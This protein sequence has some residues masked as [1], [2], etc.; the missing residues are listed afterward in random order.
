MELKPIETSYNGYR[1]R[2]RLEARWAVFFDTVGIKWEYETEG[3]DLGDAGWYL[4][5]FWLPE[6]NCFI[7]IKGKKPTIEECNKVE[8]LFLLSGFP[9]VL[10]YGLPFDNYG[11]AYCATDKTD[12]SGGCFYS[13][14]VCWVKYSDVPEID[15]QA[16]GHYVYNLHTYDE[17]PRFY[18]NSEST[19]CN[20]DETIHYQACKF[21][22]AINAAKSARFE[23]GETPITIPKTDKEHNDKNEEQQNEYYNLRNYSVKELKDYISCIKI[24]KGIP[25]Q[26]LYEILDLALCWEMDWY[27]PKEYIP[28]GYQEEYRIKREWWSKI[29]DLNCTGHEGEGLFDL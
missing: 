13:N 28:E 4:P 17:I 24:P 3:Y 7:E 11:I 9:C 29:F 2:S 26:I 19:I 8:K 21:E 5:D 14:K 16:P 12:S 27:T 10:F 20:L 23:H 15:I 1:F 25:D 22:E 6:S 18:Y